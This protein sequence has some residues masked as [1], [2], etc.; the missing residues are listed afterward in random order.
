MA[1]NDEISK[2]KDISPQS[3]SIRFTVSHVDAEDHEHKPGRRPSGLYD[4]QEGTIARGS[5]GY[6]TLNTQEAYP[7]TLY[8]RD[9][10]SS[11]AI[12][13]KQ[14]P[15]LRELHEAPITTHF[16]QKKSPARIPHTKLQSQSSEEGTQTKTGFISRIFSGRNKSK[17]PD[18]EISLEKKKRKC[19]PKSNTKDRVKF[20]WIRGVLIRCLLNI[21][22]VM[23]FIRLSWVVGQAGIGYASLIILLSTLVTLLT[24][25]SMSAIATNGEI[26]GGGAYYLISRSLGP[27][28]GGAIGIV[29]SIANVVAV[30]L[31]V[32]GFSETLKDLI[33][34]Y[35]Y[36]PPEHEINII[37]L[38]GVITVTI[39]LG[40]TLVGLEW[41]AKVQLVLLAILIVAMFDFVIGTFFPPNR[42]TWRPEIPFGLSCIQGFS[43][44]SLD[45][46]RGNW[47][48]SYTKG[49][50]FISVF[51]IFFP[52]AT[53]IL[54]G[55]NISGDLKNPQVA[56][57]RGTFI[58]II[59]S[60]IVYLIMAW[61]VSFVIAREAPGICLFNE[62]YFNSSLTQ[63]TTCTTFLP[64]NIT[65]PT[66][67]NVALWRKISA[68]CVMDECL[69]GLLENTQMIRLSSATGFLVTAGIFSA[70][71]SS[72]L[73]S[74]ISA[75]KIFQRVCRDR[76]FPFIHIFG[77]G[78]WTGKGSEP[79]RGY[80]LT[81]IIAVAFILIGSLNE[82]APIISNFFLA[83]YLLINYAT[84]TADLGNSPGWRPSFKFYNK[85]VSLLAALLCL[86]I[87][88][89]IQ[90]ETA[91]VTVI[92]I[93]LL[94]KYVDFRKPNVNWGSSTQ[95]YRHR[96]AIVNLYKLEKL[97][98]HVKNFRPQMLVLTGDPDRTNLSQTPDLVYLAAHIIRSIGINVYGQVLTGDFDSNVRNADEIERNQREWLAK[99]K[100][101][102]F[103]NCVIAKDYNQ[104]VQS[105]L[106][107]AGVGKLKPNIL[108]MGYPEKWRENSDEVLEDYLNT[109]HWAFDLNFGVCLFRVQNREKYFVRKDKMYRYNF[110]RS[111]K[112][113]AYQRPNL[114]NI[115]K[116]KQNYK[117]SQPTNQDG[118]AVRVK[119]APLETML[120][121]DPN[122]FPPDVELNSEKDEHFDPKAVTSEASPE[123]HSATQTPPNE[124]HT[125]SSSDNDTESETDT[126]TIDSSNPVSIFFLPQDKG[127]IDVWWL[128]DDGG[129]ALLL[130]HLLT[131]HKK[132]SGVSL[133]IFLA[134]SISNT[135][136]KHKHI[137][138][139]K[140]FR[141]PFSSV[142][143]VSTLNEPPSNES[144]TLYNSFAEL[145]DNERATFLDQ[146]TT[147]MIRLGELLRFYSNSA[148]LI[149]LTIPIPR[150]IS[151][152]PR[153]YLS[154][155]EIVSRDLP[156]TLLMRGNQQDLNLDQSGRE[157]AWSLYNEVQKQERLPA[158]AEPLHWLV[159][160][161]YLVCSQTTVES[162]NG[163]VMKGSGVSLVQ[164]LRQ[165]QLSLT[166]FFNLIKVWIERVHASPKESEKLKSLELKFLVVQESF[167]KYKQYFLQLFKSSDN[168]V[169]LAPMSIKGKRARSKSP[170]SP[171]EIFN[172]GWSLLL[173]AKA[174]Y[175]S[176][177][178]NLV[179]SHYLLLTSLDFLYSNVTACNR[180]EL[181]NETFPG[182]PLTQN[183]GLL[184][185][186][187]QNMIIPYLVNN[188][189]DILRGCENISTHYWIPFISRL[190]EFGIL[191]DNK[192]FNNRENVQISITTTGLFDVCVFNQN[193]QSIVNSYET[194]VL[195]ENE[196]DE[197][198]FLR[199]NS[200]SEIGSFKQKMEDLSLQENSPE[201]LNGVPLSK[202]KPPATPLTSKS[203]FMAKPTESTPF[204]ASIGESK[205]LIELGKS[206]GPYPT[207]SLSTELNILDPTIVSRID[208]A[209]DRFLEIFSK[210][211]YQDDNCTI[212]IDR[213]INTFVT[214]SKTLCY[215][216]LEFMVKTE[217]KGGSTECDLHIISIVSKEIFLKTLVAMCVEIVLA[218]HNS[219]KT[220]PWITDV[221]DLT[222]F[223]FCQL[224]QPILE[225]TKFL[226][227]AT[228]KHLSRIEE[229]ILEELIWKNSSPL[230]EV[231]KMNDMSIPSWEEVMP[232]EQ[233]MLI[234][235]GIVSMP[236]L[237]S[238]PGASGLSPHPLRNCF[239]SPRP[240][241]Y[242]SPLKPK[243]IRLEKSQIECSSS[244]PQSSATIFTPKKDS[245]FKMIQTH[246]VKRE[247]TPEPS[248][249]SDVSLRMSAMS[250][251]I[252]KSPMRD[253]EPMPPSVRRTFGIQTF[254]TLNPTENNV[255]S[256]SGTLKPPRK[257]SIAVF[258]KK[259]YFLAHTR[260]RDLCSKLNYELKIVQVIWTIF[261]NCIK[262]K[263]SLFKERHLDQIL[264]SSIYIVSRV[265]CLPLK[266][267]DLTSKYKTQPQAYA[268]IFRS[269]LLN[270]DQDNSDTNIPYAMRGDIV[271]FYN[272]VFLKEMESF[273]KSIGPGALNPSTASTLSPLPFHL[274][275][276][277]PKYRRIDTYSQ[278]I[279][280]R[281]H[282]FVPARKHTTPRKVIT[283]PLFTPGKEMRALNQSINE[284]G[285]CKR[286]ID[287]RD[288]TP[289]DDLS[290][291]LS[292]AKRPTAPYPMQRENIVKLLK[293]QMLTPDSD[294]SDDGEMDL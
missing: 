109:I 97:P 134:S 244:T 216:F 13:I 275:M 1:S 169:R 162:V 239:Q 156:P 63:N 213:V 68:P 172:F 186:D 59:L 131:R 264:L 184:A 238:T 164:M 28:L 231:L 246:P 143:E 208:C 248:E 153:K 147:R 200:S 122:L 95:A 146:K 286:R 252:P 29:F 24:T 142:E 83:S 7:N 50:T 160:S 253:V 206:N 74:L 129:L 76:I 99:N 132:W 242:H 101:R 128:Y 44:Y 292:P 135:A 124:P 265:L 12:E 266:F 197:R 207:A 32:I 260:L 174:H 152:S 9:Q 149:I 66:G 209:I 205:W 230:W 37:R 229:R 277:L 51:A 210:H 3:K 105:L 280:V 57:P 103:Y 79:I 78:G 111:V 145:D 89:F 263:S 71:L 223:D 54:A 255:Y 127:T 247:P 236:R 126:E 291:I 77:V 4:T 187:K 2:S 98:E 270:N 62:F 116:K 183:E 190:T 166:K 176:I 256:T 21:W 217:K 257:G 193:L 276:S 182:F 42:G 43:G 175:P 115:G 106:Q 87:M 80:F 212:P 6:T 165:S 117:L 102:G 49:N 202:L 194:Y 84:F 259:I 93:L 177:A 130:P 123:P 120:S 288:E 72:A 192:S 94:Y 114:P 163:E 119:L 278:P 287:M 237:N 157:K 232:K 204:T 221:L 91:L 112:R 27:N 219:Q 228:V 55:A 178:D 8:Y 235:K 226:S 110:M 52:A 196:L 86:L 90:W 40:V 233:R 38:I 262:E 245:V 179:F 113:I 154:W 100:L 269:V 67:E 148:R 36:L 104:G 281:T 58:A 272:K 60:S 136:Q 274:T 45:T 20:G 139:L 215:V 48:D 133:R 138:M 289:N 30:A 121:V 211:F 56:I 5:I 70:T 158:M 23:L 250:S 173:L 140:R 284:R 15:T 150:R 10:D 191:Q 161:L 65:C 64:P 39:L 282:E 203:I 167:R 290:T 108:Y 144:V 82:I 47:A 14:R 61:I 181:L 125:N 33:K 214:L 88:F 268:I 294:C 249:I 224:I 18:P 180:A 227:R 222:E 69:F 199:D 195:R 118:S 293:S 240:L 251:L 53:G 159:C 185:D 35:T 41:E 75:P 85:W 22:G 189:G 19:C 92:L 141:I 31:Y 261:E 198:I 11:Q 96:T 188:D 171:S 81:Y 243:P 225:Y 271:Q 170:C 267:E 234:E 151:I 25:M 283:N 279:Y 241:H 168:P 46:F 16:T 34:D 220:F 218:V 107:L 73:T 254:S 273:A 137:Q 285:I 201:P 258:F 17:P 26:K 155:L